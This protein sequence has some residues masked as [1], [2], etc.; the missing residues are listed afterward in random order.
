MWSCCQAPPGLLQGALADKGPWSSAWL[1]AL[2]ICFWVS[3]RSEVV[4]DFRNGRD[5]N[6]WQHQDIGE[7]VELVCTGVR[8]CGH[9]QAM[10]GGPAR[11]GPRGHRRSTSCHQRGRGKQWD[12]WKPEQ[13][14][15]A[16]PARVTFPL[17]PSTC[18]SLSLA[19]LTQVSLS[20][21]VTVLF[22]FRSVCLLQSRAFA[23]AAPPLSFVIVGC[24]GFF[25][26]FFINRLNFYSNLK[27][28]LL[29]FFSLTG[30]QTVSFA[31]LLLVVVLNVTF[32][33]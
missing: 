29:N 14:K 9:F 10:A 19:L 25:V 17:C 7:R 21:P 26:C 22:P 15:G 23:H 33:T 5:Y 20:G 28:P 3:Q 30:T 8:V 4:Y 27:W 13:E 24:C 2:H 11:H 16:C 1:A 12:P 6:W 32:G 31:T 18:R